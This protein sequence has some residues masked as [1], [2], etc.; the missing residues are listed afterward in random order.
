M[1]TASSS[2]WSLATSETPTGTAARSTVSTTP[3]PGTTTPAAPQFDPAMIERTEMRTQIVMAMS[4]VS[5]PT[6]TLAMAVLRLLF[7]SNYLLASLV[8]AL[9]FRSRMCLSVAL[10]DKSGSV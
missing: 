10:Q 9:Y 7:F 1:P 8:I 3:V 4:N 2:I 6:G 5:V